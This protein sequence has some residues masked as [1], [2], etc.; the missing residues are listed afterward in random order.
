MILSRAQ[1][2]LLVFGLTSRSVWLRVAQLASFVPAHKL[3]TMLEHLALQ[4]LP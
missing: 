3:I 2:G 1:G 4:T